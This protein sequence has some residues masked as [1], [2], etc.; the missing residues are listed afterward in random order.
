MHFP[1]PIFQTANN[2]VGHQRMIGIYRIAATGVIVKN[3]FVGFIMMIKNIIANAP[4]VNNGAIGA[5][6]G[7]M[8]KHDVH[9]DAHARLM[10]RFN[11]IAEFLDMS[12]LFRSDAIP[13]MWAKK[14][15]GAVTP[16][17]FQPH[18]GGIFRHILLIESHHRQQF[19]MS[20]AEFFQVR[21]FFY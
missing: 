2:E 13:R 17:V 4:E 6:L 16:V 5:S 11:Q 3:A 20:N 14:T 15:V 7:G 1:D 18:I 12:A 21:D 9:N 8:V 19:N 10:Q